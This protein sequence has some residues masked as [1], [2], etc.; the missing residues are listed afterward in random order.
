MDV[1]EL[2]V[3]GAAKASDFEISHSV[4]MGRS[5]IVVAARCTKHG[6]PNPQKLYALKLLFNFTQEYTSVM[7]NA[8]ENEWLVL[9]RVMPH[10]SIVRFWA[11]FISEIP[12]GLLPH[13]PP[14][15]RS[16]VD[17]SSRMGATV[18]RKGQFL[19]LDFHRLDLQ[20]WLNGQQCP[21]GFEQTLRFT[22]QL[23]EAT[24]Y[25]E[26]AL[27]RHLDLKPANILVAEGD[28]LVLCDFGCAL[29]F[30]DSSFTLRYA[31][32]SLPGGNRAHL[33]PEVVN[34]HHLLRTESSAAAGDGTISYLKETSFAVGV[35]A[36]EIATSQHPLLDYPLAYTSNG[37]AVAYTVRDIQPLPAFY[38]NSFCS[39][40]T[41]L[42]NPDPDKRISLTEA[43]QQLRL[44]CLRKQSFV[45]TGGVQGE[46]DRIK[47]ERD[48][49]KVRYVWG[50]CA[51]ALYF[52]CAC[53]GPSVAT[54]YILGAGV[55]QDNPPPPPP[56]PPP[57]TDVVAH[58]R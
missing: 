49:A 55:V 52:V 58:V 5:G 19:V 17:H 50:A 31:R 30:S 26:N 3:L 1:L 39:I 23:L 15:I 16:T 43:L 40:V 56:P 38:P 27:I 42:L 44:C 4:G 2:S 6:L 54:L 9:S 45:G 51:H 47:Q 12:D 41:D 25:L 37:G 24:L 48:L 10:Q 8:Y 29:Q 32:G 22:E 46:L 57:P 18:R 14:H 20:A 53:T 35:L 13:L 11:Q 21:L 36:H 28:R 33:A 7:R 34:K